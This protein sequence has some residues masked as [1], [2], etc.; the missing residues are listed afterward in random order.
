MSPKRASTDRQATR[1]GA[2]TF[3]L[4]MKK[5][6]KP[7]FLGL[8]KWDYCMAIGEIAA[9]DCLKTRES[10]SQMEQTYERFHE[11]RSQDRIR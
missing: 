5:L 9:N 10:L 11:R 2:K 1:T 6:V 7:G 4:I 3:E 8:N